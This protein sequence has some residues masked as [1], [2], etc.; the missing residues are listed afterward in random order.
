MTRFLAKVTLVAIVGLAICA[1]IPPD[2][3]D[4]NISDDDSATLPTPTP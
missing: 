4:I 1:C 3:P 2:R